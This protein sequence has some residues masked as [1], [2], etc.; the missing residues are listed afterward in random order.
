[1]IA[2]EKRELDVPK[3]ISELKTLKKRKLD[4]PEK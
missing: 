1:M 4:V 3:R 2:Q